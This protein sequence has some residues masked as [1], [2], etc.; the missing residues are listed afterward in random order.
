MSGYETQI[1]LK[2]DPSWLILFQYSNI[3]IS[4]TIVH[5]S[6]ITLL[7]RRSPHHTAS[8]LISKRMINGWALSAAGYHQSEFSPRG[9]VKINPSRHRYDVKIGKQWDFSGNTAELAIIVQN[10][11][12]EEYLEYQEGNVFEQISFVQ[13]TLDF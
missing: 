10:I 2:P 9:G 13:L 1:Q 3:R 7:G 8:F 12:N 4:G 6:K 5:P 11:T